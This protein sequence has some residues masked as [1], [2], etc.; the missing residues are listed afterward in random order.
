VLVNNDAAH[1]WL[2]G[3]TRTATRTLSDMM[4]Q[5]LAAPRARVCVCSCA[6]L[7]EVLSKAVHVWNSIARI[8]P[9]F[10]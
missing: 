4:E 6:T 3:L 7:F 1:R 9:L 8:L 5:P 10:A 2:N